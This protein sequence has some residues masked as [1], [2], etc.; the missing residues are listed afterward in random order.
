MVVSTCFFELIFTLSYSTILIHLSI[1]YKFNRTS[2]KNI[3]SKILTY[4]RIVEA[5]KFAYARRPY[6]GDPEF[7]KDPEVGL[8]KKTF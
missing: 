5:M 1:D 6:F 4:H 3:D 7:V 2:I 8:G